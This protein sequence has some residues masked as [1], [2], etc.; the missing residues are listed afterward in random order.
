VKDQAQ[1][2]PESSVPF[3]FS[4]ETM[5]SMTEAE[6]R[7]EY[8]L[9]RLRERRPEAIDRIIELRGHGC[10]QLR[11][12]KI[13][14]V[15]HRTVAAVDAAYPEAIETAYQKRVHM[16]LSAADIQVEQMI[17]EPEKVPWNIKALAASQL[18]DKAL[19]MDGRAN[20]RVE[21]T[22]RVDLFSDWPDFVRSLELREQ[23]KEIDSEGPS[24]EMQ[25]MGLPSLPISGQ[26]IKGEAPE[27]PIDMSSVTPSEISRDGEKNCSLKGFPALPGPGSKS[28]NGS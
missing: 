19:V 11:I 16:L 17:E 10:G 2:D 8:N 4:K 26:E 15:H 6:R 28:E 13:L 18:Y 23:V 20:V 24:A 3:L 21:H 22:G 7:G 25:A 5:E 27:N 14:G 1:P 12:A 9:E